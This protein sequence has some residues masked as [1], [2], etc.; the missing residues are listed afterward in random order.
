[1]NP[2]SRKREINTEKVVDFETF[3][4]C[5]Y[6]ESNSGIVRDRRTHFE[7]GYLE[8]GRGS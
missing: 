6:L 8:K 2:Y 5:P 1:M 3:T 4:T 7:Q